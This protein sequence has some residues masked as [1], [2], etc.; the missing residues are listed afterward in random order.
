M[1]SVIIS[2]DYVEDMEAQSYQGDASPVR[3]DEMI[4]L[5]TSLQAVMPQKSNWKLGIISTQS[6]EGVS[7][8]ANGLARVVA[9]NSKARVLICDVAG[10]QAARSERRRLQSNT[11]A[12]VDG[13]GNRIEFSWLP[14]S[15]IAVGTLGDA[16]GSGALTTDASSVRT[17]V[18]TVSANFELVILDL[19]PVSDGVIGP[20]LTK[21]V[22]G[23]LL[24]V[25]AE[26]TRTDS[27]RATQKALQMH[28]GKVLGVVLNKRRYHV[29]DFVSRRF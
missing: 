15:Q 26:R 5:F 1:N 10:I 11:R 20:S 8:I 22:D 19:P 29:P 13:A 12:S 17:M 14:G 2:A 9:R 27:V 25:E 28:G 4:N 6:G 16:S 7:T 21:A 3:D 23:V 24:V 18:N